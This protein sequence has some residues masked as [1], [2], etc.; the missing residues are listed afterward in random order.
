MTPQRLAA[1][2]T[3]WARTE[4]GRA[5]FAQDLGALYRAY[6]AALERIGRTDAARHARAVSDALRVAPERWGPRPVFL[7]GFD[8]LTPAQ[9]DA[10]ETLAAV[11]DAGVTVS[12]PYEPGRAAFLGP[13]RRLPA[14]QRAGGARR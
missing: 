7:Y 12:L 14:A 4:P 5:A 9:L 10:I 11:P 8:D 6:D 1:A 3:E 13:R 2:L